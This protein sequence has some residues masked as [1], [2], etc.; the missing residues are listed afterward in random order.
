MERSHL[1]MK[2][3]CII[4]CWISA[5]AMKMEPSDKVSQK[6]EEAAQDAASS[7]EA[8]EATAPTTT[9]TTATPGPADPLPPDLAL[10]GANGP[11]RPNLC[12]CCF[13]F[14]SFL[15]LCWLAFVCLVCRVTFSICSFGPPSHVPAR[16]PAYLSARLAVPLAR[17]TIA[18]HHCRLRGPKHNHCWRWS[19]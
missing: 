4:F 10:H 12:C 1:R 14:F 11:V 3:C 19:T 5:R 17:S 8:T 18:H 16:V 15:C 13:F 7:T 6:K 9:T 2:K